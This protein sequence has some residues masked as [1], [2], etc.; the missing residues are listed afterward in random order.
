MGEKIRISPQILYPMVTIESINPTT[1]ERMLQEIKA[2]KDIVPVKAVL[3][4]GYYIIW[5]GIYEMLAMNI[6][7]K[8]E[9][10]IDIIVW[11]ELNNWVSEE[12]IEKQLRIVGMNALY[13]F[14]AIGG[15]KY[16]EYPVFYK[17]G[18]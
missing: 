16:S 4:K 14:E 10:D 18:K 3:F 12:N 9:I 15:F 6:I 7:G 5:E 2:G 11:Q 8:S 1:L 17:G 13:D